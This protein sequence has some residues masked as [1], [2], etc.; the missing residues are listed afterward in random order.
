[1][2]DLWTLAELVARAAVALGG[3]AEQ[4]S[5]RVREIPDARTIRWYQ[6]TGLVDRPLALRGRTALYGRRQ[7]LQLVAIKRLQAQG[8]SLAEI[9][10]EL[11]GLSTEALE[12][13]ADLPPQP[14]TTRQVDVIRDDKAMIRTRFWTEH[15]HG[16]I[17]AEQPAT[18]DESA[19]SPAT[20]AE[21]AAASA[22][23]GE[24]LSSPV[25]PAEQATAAPAGSEQP[26]GSAAS[27]QGAVTEQA[28]PDPAVPQSPSDPGASVQRAAAPTADEAPTGPADPAQRAGAV[29]RAGSESH[30][31]PAASVQR[32]AAGEPPARAV[33]RASFGGS[34]SARRSGAP[35]AAGA[36]ATSS[37]AGQERAAADDAVHGLRLADGV[38]LVLDHPT[39]VIDAND[40][41]ALREAAA[42]LL[43]AL[44]R[45]GLVSDHTRTKEP[46]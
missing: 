10:A 45:R 30:G 33:E 29:T 25:T 34:A 13:I 31:S 2:T 41:Q 4:A 22:T 44:V 26:S 20:P 14:S 21:R 28:V 27:A 7:L 9:Q 39:S 37:E 16:T 24:P 1:M 32:A 36:P 43:D 42:P 6:T 12:P 35:A 8:R 23:A 17:P 15:N 40:V 18:A 3:T 5:A 38:L 19:S 46:A 11:A